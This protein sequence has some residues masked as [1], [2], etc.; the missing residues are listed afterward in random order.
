[1]LVRRNFAHLFDICQIKPFDKSISSEII[2]H[3]CSEGCSLFAK[4]VGVANILHQL[5]FCV[6]ENN[7]KLTVLSDGCWAGLCFVQGLVGL[8][9]V[10]K[11][12]KKLF[13]EELFGK[14]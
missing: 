5:F 8:L 13:A 4:N 11:A 1:M 10:V 7:K 2:D 3:Q 9:K 14:F 12:K 6:C